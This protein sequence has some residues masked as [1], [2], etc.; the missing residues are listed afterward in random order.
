MVHYRKDKFNI[1]QKVFFKI[2]RPFLSDYYYGIYSLKRWDLNNLNPS[3]V[4]PKSFNEKI[5]WLSIFYRKEIHTKLADKILIRDHFKTKLDSNIFPR[6]YGTWNNPKDIDWNKLPNSFVLKTNH[7]SNTN[8]IVHNKNKLNIKKTIKKFQQ[9]LSI[10]QYRLGREWA[11][12][13]IN[14]KIFAEELLLTKKTQLPNDYKLFCFNGIPKI[15]QVD[16]NRFSDHKRAFFS[17]EWESL[18]ILNEY[19]I[20]DLKIVKPQYLNKMIDIARIV[21]EDIPFCRVDLYS[22][23][24]IKLGEITFYPDAAQTQFYPSFWNRKL[25]D[26]IDLSAI[27]TY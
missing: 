6:I 4:N 12:K 5:R 14:K 13:N 26:Y 20:P 17:T 10:N 27:K 1:L 23:P 18:N 24:E 3:L 2:I 25:G 21:S 7:A 11:Y 16:T 19:N 9:F 15:I 22:L 8:L